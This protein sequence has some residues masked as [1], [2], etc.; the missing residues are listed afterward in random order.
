MTRLQ[1]DGLGPLARAAASVPQ[2]RFDLLTKVV[3]S[4]DNNREGR[5]HAWYA[6]LDDWRRRTMPSILNEEPVCVD[7]GGFVVDFDQPLTDKFF[8]CSIH[9]TLRDA[10]ASQINE[11]FA[12][13][14]TGRH[15]VNVRAINF[16][17]A[18]SDL[19]FMKW[20][21]PTDHMP[22]TPKIGCDVIPI[23]HQQG[24]VG[25]FSNL[26]ATGIRS[27]HDGSALAWT[28]DESSAT[29]V[30]WKMS[31]PSDGLWPADHWHLVVKQ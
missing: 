15:T 16:A 5:G 22:A 25:V 30:V 19:D 6:L 13:P 17:V 8:M 1:K 29:T 20:C 14:R 7:L 4:V 10:A 18:T 2:A 27:R 28:Y 3:S 26:I 12:E 24:R 11:W 31:P 21:I 9:K 23:L